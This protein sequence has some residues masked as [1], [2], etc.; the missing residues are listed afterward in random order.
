M[1]RAVTLDEKFMW[2]QIQGM[3]SSKIR[4][5]FLGGLGKSSAESF[6]FKVLCSVNIETTVVEIRAIASEIGKGLQAKLSS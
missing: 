1:L 3:R 6:S 5:P 4:E 2:F